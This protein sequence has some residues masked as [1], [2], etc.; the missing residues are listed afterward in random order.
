MMRFVWGLMVALLALPAAAEIK[1]EEVT[2]PGG[3]KAW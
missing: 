2:S 1:I 3:I